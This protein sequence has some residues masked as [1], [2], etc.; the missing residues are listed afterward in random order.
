MSWKVS[1][2][3][4]P[5]PTRPVI[6]SLIRFYTL[7]PT[8]GA[9][10]EAK[11]AKTIPQT[12]YIA[13]DSSLLSCLE[14]FTKADV[15]ADISTMWAARRIH[16]MR[17][18]D[19]VHSPT[20]RT[21][22]MYGILGLS[23]YV[24]AKPMPSTGEASGNDGPNEKPIPQYTDIQPRGQSV[25][26]DGGVLGLLDNAH[27]YYGEYDIQNEEC[28]RE[29]EHCPARQEQDIPPLRF[30]TRQDTTVVSNMGGRLTEKLTRK[31]SSYITHWRLPA[32]GRRETAGTQTDEWSGVQKGA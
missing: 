27:Y 3:L 21:P 13:P 1:W 30:T 14:Q 4:W 18:A 20:L 11:I 7:T 24:P 8:A 15:E 31:K 12:Q 6:K 29:N 2:M 25:Q 10:G 9:L 19:L 32:P 28:A 26:T 16:Q 17:P 5:R 23:S 22:K